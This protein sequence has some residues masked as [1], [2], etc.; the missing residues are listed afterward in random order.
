MAQ[1]GFRAA[2]RWA[3]WPVLADANPADTSSAR[4]LGG[5]RGRGV[6]TPARADALRVTR[7]RGHTGTPVFSKDAV[8]LS[9]PRGA[10][11]TI[12]SMLTLPA[13]VKSALLWLTTLVSFVGGFPQSHCICPDGSRHALPLFLL[14]TDPSCCCGRGAGTP[15]A[16]SDPRIAGAVFGHCPMCDGQKVEDSSGDATGADLGKRCRQSITIADIMASATDSNSDQTDFP[17]A[18]FAC[19]ACLPLLDLCARSPKIPPSRDSTPPPPD[20]VI[21]L[22]HIVV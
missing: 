13:T 17:C 3:P 7:R 6:W 14:A 15:V 12:T 19:L 5:L 4:A 10:G 9:Q 1:A 11:V 22:L 8:W 2:S 20:L 18:D 16:R 21:L